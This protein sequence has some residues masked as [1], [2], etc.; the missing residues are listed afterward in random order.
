MATVAVCT[1]LFQTISSVYKEEKIEQL[2]VMEL[3]YEAAELLGW[4]PT[5]AETLGWSA[6]RGKFEVTDEDRGRLEKVRRIIQKIELTTGQTEM[7]NLLKMQYLFQY[8]DFEQLEAL[9]FKKAGR[10]NKNQAL[11][12]LAM[13]YLNIDGLEDKGFSYME[14]ALSDEPE[15]IWLKL[16]YALMLHSHMRNEES[17]A[18]LNEI[19][20]ETPFQD[21]AVQIL[22]HVY[23]ESENMDKAKDLLSAYHGSG[24]ETFNSHY[25]LGNIFLYDKSYK[26]AIGEYQKGLVLYQESVL[27]HNALRIAYSELDQHELSDKHKKLSELY[28]NISH[29]GD[30]KSHYE[31]ETKSKVEEYFSILFSDKSSR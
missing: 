10:N 21:D 15:S 1:T 30:K 4:K 2:E 24:S 29:G 23:S 26:G 19:L 22:A 6:R 5:A 11:V 18:I 20:L 28:S 16:N 13:L 25:T 14:I 8:G 27:I 9:A 7:L 17:V 12:L 31:F 3:S